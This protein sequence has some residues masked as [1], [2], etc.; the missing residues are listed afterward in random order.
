MYILANG[1]IA[2]VLVLLPYKILIEFTMT[3]MGP[4]TLLFLFSF[5]ALRIK[6]PDMPR[7]FKIPGGTC[8]AFLAII[9]PCVVTCS[10]LYFAARKLRVQF[11][12]K[13]QSLLRANYRFCCCG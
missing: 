3:V 8:V 2:A 10:Q 12:K 6:E 13:T 9:P 4:P 1:A 7:D 11:T 5:V